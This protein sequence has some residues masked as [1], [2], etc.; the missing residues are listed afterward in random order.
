MS[1]KLVLVLNCG[2]SSLKFAVINANN[3]DEVIS[4]LAECFNLPDARIKWK[5]DGKKEE[6]NLPENSAHSAAISFIVENIIKKI[7]GLEAQFI[8]VGH[9]VV[10]GGEKFSKSVIIDEAVLARH[11][12]MCFTCTFT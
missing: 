12:R 10:H 2:S 5:F 4:G 7:D 6:A 8:A 11:S 3:G 9:R 1:N